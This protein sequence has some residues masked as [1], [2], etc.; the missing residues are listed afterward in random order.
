MKINLVGE[1]FEMTDNTRIAELPQVPEAKGFD[2]VFSVTSAEAMEDLRAMAPAMLAL[3]KLTADFSRAYQEEKRRR[4]A[5]DFSDQEHEAIDLLL[6]ADGQP[7]GL[8]RTVSQRYREIMVDEYQ[9]TNEVQNCIF[10][11]ISREG[12]NLFTVGDVKQSIYRFRLADPRIFLD[13]Y[14]H[15]PHAVDAAEGESAKLLL[16]KNFRSRD[17]VLDAAN[18]VFR[19]VLSREMGELDYGEDESLHVGASYPENPDCCTEFHFVEMSAQESDTEKLRAARAEASFA[20]DY[21]QR[22]IAGGFTVQDD[23]THEPRAVRE[24]D[25]VIL[26]RSPRTRLADY[27]R[28]LESRGLHCAAESDGGFYETMEVAV[29]F[30]LL[31]ILDNPRQDVPLISVLRSPLFGFTP[32][33]LAELRAKTPG[34]D[35]YDALAA[36]GGEDSARFLALLRELGLGDVGDKRVRDYSGGMRRR[37]ALARALLAPSDALVLDEPLTG[38]DTEN[39]AAA[40]RCILRAAEEKPVLL[41]AHETLDIPCRA[42][43]EL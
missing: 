13:H 12:K 11:A 24:E 29:T 10:S 39:R 3:L 22:L 40:L 5:A 32:D 23:K 28:A 2:E 27:R 19:N 1:C 9:D 21:I 34:G 37:L 42:V 41:S 17:T 35:F 20:A 31:E 16:S 43:V 25:I 26:M 7:T 36:D 4:N 38:L 33:R 15:Y 6:G 18:F 14:L 8:A 30:A